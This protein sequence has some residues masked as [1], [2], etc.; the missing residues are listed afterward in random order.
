MFITFNGCPLDYKYCINAHC[1]NKRNSKLYIDLNELC[2]E[3][4][5][6]ST[7][8]K[9]TSGGI[10]FIS[11]EPLLNAE[12]TEKFGTYTDPIVGD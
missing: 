1:K 2:E 6:G 8:F 12:Y 11:G 3:L 10:I 9:M 4:S 5:K 7:Y